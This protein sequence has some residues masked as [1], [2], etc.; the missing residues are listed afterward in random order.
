MLS[1]LNLD[2]NVT[3]ISHL[4]LQ[5]AIEKEELVQALS[6]ELSQTARVKVNPSPTMISVWFYE[7]I[8]YS[9]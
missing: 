4:W 2:D 1:F 5:L 6:T 9:P 3:V 8:P 7:L